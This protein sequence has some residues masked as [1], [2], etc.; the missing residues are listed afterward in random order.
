MSALWAI[1]ILVGLVG[2]YVLFY[3]LNENTQP[4]EG[5]E[6]PEDFSGCGACHSS[7]CIAR[8]KPPKDEKK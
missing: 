8:K 6:L 3:L 1:L 4:P 2:I 7:G 5:C